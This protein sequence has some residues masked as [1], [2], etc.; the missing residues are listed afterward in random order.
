VRIETSQIVNLFSLFS[1]AEFPVLNVRIV[2]Q[3]WP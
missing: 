3:K 2:R 1:P